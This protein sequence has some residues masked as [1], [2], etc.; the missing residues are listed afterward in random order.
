M[1]YFI[2]LNSY[3]FVNFLQNIESLGDL[4]CLNNE[5]DSFNWLLWYTKTCVQFTE[6]KTTTI[7]MKP[8]LTTTDNLEWLA[9]FKRNNT[10]ANNPLVR[11][12]ISSSFYWICSV[13]IAIITLSCLFIAWFYCWKRYSLSRR[14]LMLQRRNLNATA[15]NTRR[16]NGRQNQRNRNQNNSFLLNSRMAINGN[17]GNSSDR[18]EVDTSSSDQNNNRNLRTSNR[19]GIN[20]NP[21]GLYYISLNRNLSN[22]GKLLTYRILKYSLF[23]TLTIYKKRY[24]IR[25]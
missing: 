20:T 12:D 6:V 7:S 22:R 8:L 19:N 4:K 11:Y 17:N 3:A 15:T 2:N 10:L 14:I 21:N 16:T 18:S 1:N 23:K 13:C 5:E 25:R 9:T 24:S